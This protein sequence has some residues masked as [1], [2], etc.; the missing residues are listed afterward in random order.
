P[1]WRCDAGE[2]RPPCPS[3]RRPPSQGPG[4]SLRLPVAPPPRSL[5][6]R[7]QLGRVLGEPVVGLSSRPLLGLF[8]RPSRAPSELA[9]RHEHGG[10][11]FLLVVR[12]ALHHAVLGHPA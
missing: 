6:L 11:E 3:C 2:P 10:G 9:P 12:T 4:A 7:G 8:L 5:M 1:A